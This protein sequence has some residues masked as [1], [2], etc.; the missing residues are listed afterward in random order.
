M[1]QRRS[2]WIPS[3]PGGP[4]G[5]PSPAASSGAGATR[6]GPVEGAGYDT[7]LMAALA[8]VRARGRRAG[9]SIGSAPTPNPSLWWRLACGCGPGAWR[10]ADGGQQPARS[11]APAFPHGQPAGQPP[12]MQAGRPEGRCRCDCI[13]E[14][15]PRP[16]RGGP[17]GG[18]P[19]AAAAGP[20]QLLQHRVVKRSVDAR[21]RQAIHHDSV[22]LELETQLEQRLL[23]RFRRDNQLQAAEGGH[24]CPPTRADAATSRGLR[25]GTV[26]RRLVVGAGPCGY[27][28]GPAAGPDGAAAAA[29]GAGSAVKQRSADTFGF[30]RGSAALRSGIQRPVRRGGRRHLLRRQAL[31]PGAANRAACGRKVLEELVA[32]V[33]TLNP[34]PAPAP[35][36]HLQAGHGGAR[37]LRGRRSRPWV[38][39]SASRAGSSGC[40]WIPSG[41]R[42]A[43][44]RA[45]RAASRHR[46]RAR[47]C[48][49]P[50]YSARDQ[51]RERCERQGVALEREALLPSGVRHR[52]PAGVVSTAARWGACRRPS[53]RPARRTYKLVHHCSGEGLAGRSV[54]SF[55][56]CPGGLVVGATSGAGPG[57]DQRHEPAH[58]QWSATPTA[59]SGGQGAFEP[60]GSSEPYAAP[61][62]A[63]PWRG[64]RFERHWEEP[65]L[66]RWP[67]PAMRRRGADPWRPFPA[68]PPS[69]PGQSHGRSGAG[70][71]ISPASPTPTSAPRLPRL[72]G[73]GPAGGPAQPSSA[74]LP[75]YASGRR[76]RSP[77][78]ETRTSS[79]LRPPRRDPLTLEST[80]H[81]RACIPAGE[82]AGYAGGILSAAIDGIKVAERVAWR[83]ARSAR[84]AHD[85]G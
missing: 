60:G 32:S 48:W 63:T 77:A 36:R 31:Q 1:A 29:A 27:F 74:V 46:R 75:G 26:P 6:P 81:P 47:C 56:M 34:H 23:K 10:P 11:S 20:E 80:Q 2:A 58:P 62:P 66:T 79:P 21:R 18:H 51:L 25:E 13:N 85:Q 5:A 76:T 53:Q 15:A 35:H 45:R 41:R 43:G 30:W 57:G 69:R 71:P 28:C 19:P 40:T 22:E 61:A 72:R 44:V 65:C 54:C 52:A 16:R 84:P 14:A 37:G 83:F 59:A 17:G 82:G 78:V 9:A 33:P 68:G 73:G 7:G 3:S 50:G 67:P 38:A 8:S 12:M 64:S 42:V 49:P 39:R 55:C 70:P 4:A 24:Y